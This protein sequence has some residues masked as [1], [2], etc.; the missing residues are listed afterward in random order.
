MPHLGDAFASVKED[1]LGL[2]SVL[3]AAEA[4]GTP[5][6]FIRTGSLADYGRTP[7][8]RTLRAPERFRNPFMQQG[9][10]PRS[11]MWRRCRPAYRSQS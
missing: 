8:P 10:S 3:A 9:W 4:S 1:V 7:M 2:L 6:M 11:I 5:R